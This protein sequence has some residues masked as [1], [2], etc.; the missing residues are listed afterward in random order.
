MDVGSNPTGS[1]FQRIRGRVVEGTGLII[2]FRKNV[3][4]S[5]PVGC[6]M[7]KFNFG[8]FVLISLPF[9]LNLLKSKVLHGELLMIVF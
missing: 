4:G 6:I 5:N 1:K 2:H 3:A 9:L 7:Y 8:T